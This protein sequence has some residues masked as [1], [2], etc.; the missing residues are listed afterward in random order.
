MKYKSCSK[1]E[2]GINFDRDNIKF[3]CQYSSRGGGNTVVIDNYN[4]GPIDWDKFFAFKHQIKELHKKG[5]TYHKCE[6]CIYLEEQEWEEE[7]KLKFF[8]LDY[9]TYCNCNCI[10]CHTHNKKDIYN[11]M[12]TYDFLPILKDLIS[13]DLLMRNGHVSFGGGEV[14]LLKEFE[15]CMKIFLDYGYFIRIHSGCMDYS[16][17]I[18]DGLKRG[19]V[20]LIVSVDSGTEDMHVKIKEVKTYDKVWGNLQRY[21]MAQKNKDLVKAKY[22]VIPGV[23]DNKEEID[24]WLDKCIS[25]GI[26]SVIQEI[27]SNWFYARR[28]ENV[29]KYIFELFDY[30]KETAIA[31][32]LN[33][34]EYERAAH[35]LA[36]RPSVFN[37]DIEVSSDDEQKRLTK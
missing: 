21:A 11:T 13:K 15:E 9:W 17:L 23:N 29:P 34:G 5:E 19:Q 14:C 36:E 1:I 4:G 16:P 20:D 30:T 35:M 24:A 33:Y 27:E 37:E 7:D 6:G 18:E 28:G 25:C 26:G 2:N 22:I 31:K 12:V 32:G 8:N 10:Y 3:C